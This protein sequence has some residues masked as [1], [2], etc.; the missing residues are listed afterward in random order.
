[1]TRPH[2]AAKR[3]VAEMPDDLK[4]QVRPLYSP[5]LSIVSMAD[6]DTI[7][8]EE[9]AIFTSSN[10]VANAPAGADR[11]AYCIGAATTERAKEH[12]WAAQLVGQTADELVAHLA[13]VP[14]SQALVHIRGRHTRGDIVSRLQAA[15]QEARDW[16][17]YDQRLH[18][19]SESAHDALLREE[20][21]I[22]P[23]FSPRTAMQFA[24]EAPRTT[25]IR[26]IALSDAVADAVQ[27]VQTDSVAVQPDATAMYEAMRQIIRAG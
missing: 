23:L 26:V 18:P 4:S 16:V 20:L 11:V 7:A 19:L 21:T 6:G 14:L 1:M 9:A 27:P 12:G 17:V 10:G 22:V 8:T 15:G 2:T 5:L 25:S 13:T 24:R 3:F